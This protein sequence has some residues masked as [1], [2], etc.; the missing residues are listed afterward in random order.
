MPEQT[1]TA[2]PERVLAAFGARGSTAQPLAGG[3][4][5]AW[6][7][8]D[9]VLKPV[10]DDAEATWVAEV[11]SGLT[12]DGF[13]I[14][15]PVRSDTGRWVIDGWAAWWVITGRHDT[16]GRWLDVLSAGA[17]LTAA[18]QGLERPAFLD[19]R[20]HAWAVADRMAWGEAPVLVI[21]DRLRPLAERLAAHVVRDDSPSQV[22][23]GDLSGNVL[24]AP[25]L[26]PGITDFTPYW[27]PA[28]FCSAV[29]V[30][31]ALLWHGAASS[32]VAA[33]PG[34]DR[35]SLLAR[36]ALYR[37]LASDSLANGMHPDAAEAYARAEARSHGRVLGLLD[38]DRGRGPGARSR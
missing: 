6:T 20:T 12:E 16:S 18:L 32:L 4:G 24:F 1:R 5:R 27:R 36:A 11:L 35:T 23:H 7:V 8:G 25:G 38:R 21:H 13:R 15:R 2:P 3:Q 28:P 17:R 22:I 30:V 10:D 9:L 14:N 19:T 31:D 26:R 37:L 34:A 33:V 29:V